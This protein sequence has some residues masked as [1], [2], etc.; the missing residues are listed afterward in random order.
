M[1][2]GSGLGQ[3]VLF[4]DVFPHYAGDICGSFGICVMD[5]VDRIN[6]A[7][8]MF[9]IDKDR[10]DALNELNCGNWKFKEDI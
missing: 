1:D 6:S 4:Q 2:L 10:I 7:L 9:R 5:L 8:R 3:G